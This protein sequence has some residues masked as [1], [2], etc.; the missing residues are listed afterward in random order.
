MIDLNGT[1]AC[2]RAGYKAKN[3]DIIASELL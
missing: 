3:A 2:I 1:A